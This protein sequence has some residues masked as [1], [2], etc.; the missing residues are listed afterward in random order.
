MLP[1]PSSEHQRE[2]MRRVKDPVGFCSVI[3]NQEKTF[4]L[5]AVNLHCL[6]RHLIAV[7]QML[8]DLI[9]RYH[10]PRTAD[11]RHQRRPQPHQSPPYVG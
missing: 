1:L 11:H 3:K 8:H 9:C 4:G 6:G 10:R 7:E 2:V 5:V